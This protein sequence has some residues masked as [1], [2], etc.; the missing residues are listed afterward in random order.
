MA[1]SAVLRVGGSVRSHI[2]IVNPSSVTPESH[3]SP[4]LEWP[5]RRLTNQRRVRRLALIAIMVLAS[6]G[7]VAAQKKD[8]CIEC[9]SQMEGDLSEPVQLVNDDIHK[10]NG[11][12]CVDCHGGDANIDDPAGAMNPRKGFV[13]KPKAQDIPRFCGK[14][15]SNAEFMKGFNPALRVDQE[16][17]YFTSIHGKRL[18]TGDQKVATCTSCHGFHGVRAVSDSRSKVFAV[19]VAETCAGCHA[20]A[21]YMKPYGI[22]SDQYD[23]YKMS[24]HANALYVKQD[25]SAPTCNDCHGNHGA[26]PPGLVSVANVCGQC[27]VRQA[28]LF[29]ASPHK[30]V[31]DAMGVGECKQCHSNHDIVKPNDEMLGVGDKAA[32]IS[33]HSEGDPGYDGAARMRKR[34]DELQA[35]I[36]SA[37]EILDRAERAGMEVSQARFNMSEARD[38]LTNARVVIHAFAPDEVDKTV[39]PGLET[40]A[41]SYQA[42]QSALDELVFR[43]K[44][45]GVSLFF[46]LFLAFLVYLKIKRI[47]GR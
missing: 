46:I 44:G 42:G 8:S 16:Q 47:E 4:Q 13:G 9:H 36:G 21:D 26:A 11:I 33:C 24:V 35:K 5:Q 18:K 10:T 1:S 12:S 31:F 34:I 39:T 22:P 3:R 29:Q 23:N 17:E 32:C 7:A 19:N 15:H 27:H 45:L 30:M 38:A 6:I 25:L 28:S 40:A 43:R 41:N 37:I 14:C 20:N 2:F